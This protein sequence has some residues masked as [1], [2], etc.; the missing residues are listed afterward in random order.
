MRN[1]FCFLILGTLGL[2]S[3]ADTNIKK[4]ALSPFTT[5]AKY[6]LLTGGLLTLAT[7]PRRHNL[8]DIQEDANK[9]KPFGD[10]SKFSDYMGQLVPNILYAGGMWLDSYF[11]GHEVSKQRSILMTKATAY[12]AAMTTVLKYT[13]REQRPDHSAKNSFPSG[14]STTAFAFASVVATQHEWY[15]G[16]GAY[17]IAA[18]VAYGRLNDNKHYT[19]DVIAGATIGMAYGY[20]LHYLATQDN[21]VALFALPTPDMKGMMMAGGY[22]F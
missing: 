18:V 14:H 20:G 2:N 6:I 10:F 12:S 9:N 21:G 3:Y 13:V 4:E 16:A 11:N 17:S 8:D 15:W 7:L 5:K 22:T 1:L 19:H